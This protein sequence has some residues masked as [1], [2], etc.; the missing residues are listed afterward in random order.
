MNG[1][2]TQAATGKALPLPRYKAFLAL[3]RTPHGII[4]MATPCFAAL[5]WLG[6]FPPLWVTVLGLVTAFSGYTAVYALNDVVDFHQDRKK[7]AM[8][9]TS[10][11]HGDIDIDGVWVRHPLAQG[12]LPYSSGVLWVAAWSSLA[13][14]GAWILNP[15]CLLIFLTGCLLEILYC[16]M[17]T[18]SHYRILISGM[19]KTL[20]AIAAVFAVDPEP[21][22]LF[23]VLLF[24]FL[25]FWE[26]GAQNIPN[27]WSD[28]RE[29]RVVGAK[30]VPVELGTHR[31]AL[32]IVGCVLTT[33][34][35]NTLVFLSSR[36]VYGQTTLLAALA[37]GIFLLLIPALKLW[38]TQSDRDAM[39][40][41]N[42]GSHYPLALTVIVLIGMVF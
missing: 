6:G 9:E 24:L 2:T 41:F 16:R 27:D 28:I 40:L 7:I 30:T 23:V 13:M 5:V 19:V 17:L 39:H 1:P 18:V 38:N 4:D 3:S 11:S 29:D 37:A 14:T 22:I 32:L 36:A 21:S 8:V 31:S 35:L 34:L 33:L 10:S 12:I 20:G 25:Y 42:H 26:M 15:I